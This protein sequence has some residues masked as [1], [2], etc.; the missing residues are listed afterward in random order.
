MELTKE[1]FNDVIIYAISELGAMG[2]RGI[3]NCMKKNGESF[4]LDCL[5]KETPWS[6]IKKYFKE[7]DGCRFNG[8]VVNG[9]L[10]YAVLGLGDDDTDEGTRLNP[11]W[12]HVC[13]DV[14]NHLVCKVEYYEEVKKIFAGKNSCEII[15]NWTKMLQESNFFERVDQIELAYRQQK[16]WDDEL[17]KKLGELNKNSEYRERLEGSKREDG[18]DSLLAILKEY[19]IDINLEQLLQYGRRKYDF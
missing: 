7:I 12:K 2:A 10:K 5:S 16:A 18:V 13:F 8:P 4:S 19:G 14:G 6:E 11:G 17:T 9:F 15:L 1:I 3:L